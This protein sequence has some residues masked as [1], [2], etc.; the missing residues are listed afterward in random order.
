MLSLVKKY[1]PF[2]MFII[3]II[4][5]LLL[6]Q[7]YSSLRLERKLREYQ[8]EQYNQNMSVL[9][10][11]IV[12]EFNKKLNA[13]EFEKNNYVVQKLKD[14]E[15]YNKSLAD[16]LKKVKGDVIAAI[17]TN[18]TIDLNSLS[19]DNELIVLDSNKYGLKFDSQYKDDGFEQ[20]IAGTS[21][22]YMI[23]NSNKWEL[24]ADSTNFDINISKINITYGFKEEN[25]TY[26]VF[27]ITKSPKVIIDD[28]TGGYII[29]KQ[30]K[31]TPTKIKKW[32][33]GPY[34]G[35]GVDKIPGNNI[36]FGWSVGVGITYDIIQW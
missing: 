9:T 7:T 2:I 30:P 34:I 16:D 6:F 15:K 13:W 11:S 32:G 19:V 21:S 35:V 14:L 22:F 36:G 33:I 24:K 27:A 5:G 31:Y 4:L 12:V 18:A 20:H 8:I 1:Y 25:N 29:Q 10:D 23:P 17:K 3:I 28:L 26:K